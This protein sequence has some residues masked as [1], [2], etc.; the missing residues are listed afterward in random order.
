MMYHPPLVVLVVDS[1]PDGLERSRRTLGG[2][3]SSHASTRVLEATTLPDALATIDRE[4]VDVVLLDPRMG[5]PTGLSAVRQLRQAAADLPIVIAVNAANEAL[6]FQAVQAGAQDYVIK[7][8]DD[9]RVLLRALRHAVERAGLARARDRLL[10]REHDARL[11]AE[12]ARADADRARANAESVER[13]A[14]F[15]SDA[16]AALA[17]T[18][19]A[20]ATLV[21]ATR[22][23]VPMLADCAVGFLA[24]EDGTLEPVEAVRGDQTGCDRV[25]AAARAAGM[26]SDVE[27]LLERAQRRGHFVLTSEPP[28]LGEAPSHALP[29]LP[30]AVIAPRHCMLVPLRARGHVLGV[31]GLLAGCE[32]RNYHPADLALAQA[33]AARTA[34]A[35]D[36]ARLYEASRRATRTR[37][38]VLG[39]VSH[40]L[41][42]PLSAI[43]MCAAA[44]DDVE[45]LTGAER[46]RLVRTIHDSVE[47][48][49]RL[50]GDLV[51]IA[52]IEAGRLSVEPRR[53]DPI[54][55][56][57][58]ALDLF[59][60]SAG[61][62][63]L[64]LADGVPDTLP[65]VIGDEQ[66][67]LQALANL[68]ANAL[69]FTPPEGVITLGA[70][71]VAGA[72]QFS[73]S[74]TGPGIEADH[75]VHIFDWFWRASHERAERGTGLGLAIAKGI[76]EAHGGRITVDSTPG[77]GATFSF[78]VPLAPQSQARLPALAPQGELASA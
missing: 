34:V 30:D 17:E 61:G 49:Q 60:M 65:A 13:Q 64:R 11:R 16:S 77:H 26:G 36:N 67:I 5:D 54:V 78:T 74:D 32:T 12:E 69:K 45:T 71:A 24:G 68:L 6:A 20:R 59:E 41:R 35:L 42:N 40:D 14:R 27:A 62:R 66:R 73:V 19:D 63:S 33:F 52:S 50:L 8:V 57:S 47:W 70:T 75:V 31:L 76:V 46:E 9:A 48:T 23:A 43:G 7:D 37:D 18:L 1:D 39:I 38:Q 15:L 2:D 55:V 28:R 21:T 29:A 53:V 72:V 51:D 58:R 56:I 10:Y 22:L 25:L 3:R 44:L 4:P